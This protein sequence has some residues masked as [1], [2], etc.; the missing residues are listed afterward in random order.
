VKRLTGEQFSKRA[1]ELFLQE[2]KQ[3]EQWH[4]I[5]F[6]DEVFRG[7]VII[8]AHGLTDAIVRCH[9]LQINPGGQV[10]AMPISDEIIALV[11]EADRNRLLSREDVQ[12]IW[13][14]AKS[15]RE[16]EAEKVG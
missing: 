3:P 4:C 16:R 14:D 1:A 12:R 5:S 15:I 2:M 13:P 8:K 6:A 10:I 11:P 9:V 7:V